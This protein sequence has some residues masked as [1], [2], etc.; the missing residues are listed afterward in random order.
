MQ[1]FGDDDEGLLPDD[2]ILRN[3]VTVVDCVGNVTDN[4]FVGFING[5]PYYGPFH[6]H[7]G[8]KMVGATHREYEG[9]PHPYIYDSAA[10]SLRYFDPRFKWQNGVLIAS[11]NPIASSDP[12]ENSEAYVQTISQ[13]ATGTTNAQ[14]N[15]SPQMMQSQTQTQN[16]EGSTSTTTSSTPLL[17]LLLL[18][19]PHQVRLHHHHLRHHHRHHR[20]LHPSPP[21]G[22]GGYGY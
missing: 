19:P 5:Q 10:D 3:I 8:R 12:V 9:R 1:R 13:Q 16:T 2:D 17:L 11:G 20:H 7:M 21:S 18:L 22:G 14:P 4:A 6:T 15:P